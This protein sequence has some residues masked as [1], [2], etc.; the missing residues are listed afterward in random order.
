MDPKSLALL[1]RI[2]Y[3]HVSDDYQVFLFGSRARGDNRPFSDIDLGIRGTS[4]L[5]SKTL[6]LLKN[7][8][9]ESNLPYRVD[10]VDFNN[11]SAHFNKIA[12][13]KVEYL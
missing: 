10:L 5:P 9:E 3:S 8:L 11:T 2:V 12:M 6:A 4:P 7:D 13:Q 1:K